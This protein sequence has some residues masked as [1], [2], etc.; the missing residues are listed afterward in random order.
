MSTINSN[1]WHF[2]LLTAESQD[3]VYRQ[4]RL[5]TLTQCKYWTRVVLHSLGWSIALAL[6]VGMLAVAMVLVY[7]LG[8]GAYALGVYLIADPSVLSRKN[9][10]GS[11]AIWAMVL[12]MFLIIWA[13][14]LYDKNRDRWALKKI[15][16]GWSWLTEKNCKTIKVE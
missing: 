15:R 16:E 3:A 1:S 13:P 2:K 10:G 9:I 4:S 6:C 7:L 8:Y 14:D 5:G 11:V 12:M